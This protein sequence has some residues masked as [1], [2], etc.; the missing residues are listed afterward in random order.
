[1]KKIAI[2]FI[3]CL[4]AFTANHVHAGG[5]VSNKTGIKGGMS[6]YPSDP[7]DNFQLPMQ[8]KMS[9]NLG[10]HVGIVSRMKFFDLIYVQPELIYNRSVYDFTLSATGFGPGSG[11]TGATKVYTSLFN[12]P[13]QVGLS[14]GMLRAYAGPVLNIYSTSGYSNSGVFTTVLT[15]F[16]TWGYQAGAGLSVSF[17]DLDLKVSG[18]GKAPTQNFITSSGSTVEVDL[19]KYNIMLSVGFMF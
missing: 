12:V 4:A 13:L 15:S 2:I 7:A 11:T 19:A 5:I 18:T 14:L 17:I 16:P 10:Y 6:F 3:V 8:G 9:Y 1:M